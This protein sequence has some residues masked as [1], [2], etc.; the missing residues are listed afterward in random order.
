M[1]QKKLGEDFLVLEEGLSGRTTVIE[2]PLEE[3]LC[4]LSSVYGALKSH[5]P[6]DLL[7]VM[8]GTNDTKGY[9]GQNADTIAMGME[10]LL[11]KAMEM[12]SAFWPR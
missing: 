12:V 1:L 9:L 6:V 2:D 5:E 4:G 7:V 8:L 3:G 11:R 10:R